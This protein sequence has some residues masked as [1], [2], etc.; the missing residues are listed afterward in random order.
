MESCIIGFCFEK[1]QFF[2][3]I[4]QIEQK[5][6]KNKHPLLYPDQVFTLFKTVFYVIPKTFVYLYAFAAQFGK[7]FKQFLFLFGELTRH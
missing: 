7:L 3:I 4:A 5:V 6:K 2:V 1:A